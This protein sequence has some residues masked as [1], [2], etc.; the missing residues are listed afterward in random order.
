[1]SNTIPYIVLCCFI[2]TTDATEYEN[3]FA[4]HFLQ[5]Y[6][7]CRTSEVFLMFGMRCSASLRFVICT[8]FL[9]VHMA[10]PFMGIGEVFTDARINQHALSI[11]EDNGIDHYKNTS[12]N[13]SV[14]QGHTFLRTFLGPLK[15]KFKK[16]QNV[17]ILVKEAKSKFASCWNTLDLIEWSNVTRLKC[18]GHKDEVRDII[19][20]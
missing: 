14:V 9:C 8:W 10:P 6:L 4:V 19:I 5:N 15:N 3:L 17:M 7:H 12:A 11:Y 18:F 16:K 1:M 13:N 2:F 20:N